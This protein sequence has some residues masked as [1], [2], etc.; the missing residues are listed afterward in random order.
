[1]FLKKEK[2]EHNICHKRNLNDGR[3][4]PR[5]QRRKK[6]QVLVFRT[7]RHITPCKEDVITLLL[8]ITN[9]KV[10]E[11]NWPAQHHAIVISD[12]SEPNAL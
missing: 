10:K 7:L 3:I 4:T 2:K 12:H 8:H 6:G 9:L 1:M 5:P 11:I